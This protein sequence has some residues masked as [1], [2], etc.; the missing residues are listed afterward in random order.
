MCSD[1]R[2]FEIRG[3]IG[4]RAPSM[5]YC[6]KYLADSVWAEGL[7]SFSSVTFLGFVYNLAFR[8]I[9]A[10]PERLTAYL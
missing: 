5:N 3:E 9:N 4:V 1:I 7:P 10:P 8:L 2:K 6:V